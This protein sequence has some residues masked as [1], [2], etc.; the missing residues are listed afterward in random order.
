MLTSSTRQ[1]YILDL[2][3]THF[4]VITSFYCALRIFFLHLNAVNH[5]KK[6]F[7][8]WGV[9]KDCQGHRKVPDFWGVKSIKSIYNFHPRRTVGGTV[10]I[11]SVVCIEVP[12]V[13]N[14][15]SLGSCKFSRVFNLQD[16]R[17]LKIK[18]LTK[19]IY[20]CNTIHRI[21]STKLKYWKEA[22]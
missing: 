9:L 17:R 12:R 6:T 4:E 7:F 19:L 1:L 16:P 2:K 3:Q 5:N 8:S 15:K 13:F 18:L 11:P 20:S 22:H 21:A 14:F 10:N